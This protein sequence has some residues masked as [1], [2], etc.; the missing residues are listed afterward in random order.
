M[1]SAVVD[2]NIFVAALLTTSPRSASRR[3]VD[4][5]LSEHFQLLIS[6]DTFDE[7]MEVMA[8]PR[9][10]AQHELTDRALITF[11][12]SILASGTMLTG[13]LILD[14]AIVRDVTDA[15]WLALAI[16]G[17]ADFLVTN[18]KRHLHRVR[19]QIKTKIVTA[20][21]FLKRLEN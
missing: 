6:P 7:L 3:V 4:A 20:H 2:T 18:D 19:K 12:R 11:G 14:P 10:R 9:I 1:P 16:E 15:K 5:L 21:A 17:N 13:K 8:L